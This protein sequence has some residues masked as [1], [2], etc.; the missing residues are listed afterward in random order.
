M[1]PNHPFRVVARLAAGFLGSIA[2]RFLLVVLVCAAGVYG[3]FSLFAEGSAYFGISLQTNKTLSNGLV[4]LVGWW[5]F[6]GKDMVSNVADRSGNGATGLLNFATT[7]VPGVLG[8]A[9]AFDGVSNDVTVSNT[10][11]LNIAAYTISGWFKAVPRTGNIGKNLIYLIY[12]SSFAEQK[13]QLPNDLSFMTFTDY[14]GGGASGTCTANNTI[15]GGVWHH[16]V[17]VQTSASFRELYIDGIVQCTDSTTVSFAG[18]PT[19]YLGSTVH[20]SY[21]NGSLDDARI[22]NRALSPQEVKALYVLGAGD[23]VATTLSTNPRTDSSAGGLVGWWT[24]DGKDTN[25]ATGQETDRSGQGN[26]GQLV[27]MSTS[28]SPV[29]GKIGQALSYQ[30]ANKSYVDVGAGSSLNLTSDMSISVW[31]KDQNTDGPLVTNNGPGLLGQYGL[32]VRDGECDGGID[33]ILFEETTDLGDCNVVWYTP[34]GSVSA[35]HWYHVVVTRRGV[36]TVAIYINGVSQTL[37]AVGSVSA[38]T[39][40]QHHTIIGNDAS[41]AFPQVNAIIDDVRIYNRALSP[42]EIKALYQL[43]K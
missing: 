27:N 1:P 41:D 8:Q 20:T 15:Q 24:F 7:T 28:T 13:I 37:T 12:S 31:Y 42:Q 23:K 26:T 2:G 17:A 30:G 4:G 29:A 5:T 32:Y 36:S 14:D 43:G 18:T 22:Y 19:L 34:G 21:W 9:L 11:N 33:R 3:Y 40:T 10:P 6:D 39:A 38:I 16:F 25:W 35:G